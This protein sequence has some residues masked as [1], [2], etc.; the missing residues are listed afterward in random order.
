MGFCASRAYTLLKYVVFCCVYQ[1]SYP[2]PSTHLYPRFGDL[3]CAVKFTRSSSE[4]AHHYFILVSD[5]AVFARYGIRVAT[6]SFHKTDVRCE[7]PLVRYGNTAPG[8]KL[9]QQLF[10]A[11]IAAAIQTA[12]G[13]RSNLLLIRKP[14]QEDVYPP[15]E[16]QVME[17][18]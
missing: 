17:M 15:A 3:S 6:F 8:I 13:V 16:H 4:S 9:P 1:I 18:D 14:A 7:Q 12:E 2:M 5:P 10:E 11:A